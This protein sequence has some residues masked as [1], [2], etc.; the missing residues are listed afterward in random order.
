MGLE[1]KTPPG[2]PRELASFR[3][4]AFRS[5]RPPPTPP[6]APTASLTIGFVSQVFSQICPSVPPAERGIIACVEEQMIV[7]QK[8]TRVALW[9]AAA[10]VMAL[11]VFGQAGK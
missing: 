3:K 1:M 6:F 8:T 9:I 11:P 4:P 7:T 10:G 2:L 5:P